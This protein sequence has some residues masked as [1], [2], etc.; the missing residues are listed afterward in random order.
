MKL[1]F[2]LDKF[3]LFL[4][5]FVIFLYAVIALL[6]I[7]PKKFGDKVFF[8]EAK[9]IAQVIHGVRQKGEIIISRA[10]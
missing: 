4:V 5:G 1:P 9:L 7:A 3:D 6:P 8:N 10:P 2:G